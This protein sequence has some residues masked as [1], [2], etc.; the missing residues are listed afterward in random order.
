MKY[1][2]AIAERDLGEKIKAEVEA[3][4]GEWVSLNFRSGLGMIVCS[5]AYR[6][7]ER[8]GFRLI[9][10]PNRPS[11]PVRGGSEKA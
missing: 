10:A 5:R 4:R 2:L 3:A 6:A 8:C 7:H 1:D 11:G 9:N